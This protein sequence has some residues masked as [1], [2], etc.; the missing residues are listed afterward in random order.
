MQENNNKFS[1]D[2]S[3]LASSTVSIPIATLIDSSNTCIMN[4]GFQVPGSIGAAILYNKL[5]NEQYIKPFHNYV[6]GIVKK[7][8]EPNGPTLTSQ[9]MDA[10]RN[11]PYRELYPKM[12][13]GQWHRTMHGHSFDNIIEV[14]KNSKLK[15]S[16]F[17]AHELTDFVTKN[18][19]PILPWSGAIIKGAV[20]F[21]NTVG[22]NLSAS[23]VASKISFNFVEAGYTLMYVA[24]AAGDIYSVVTNSADWSLEYSKQVM[25]E[26]GLA[27]VGGFISGQKPIA[28][29]GAAQFASGFWEYYNTPTLL[30]VPVYDIVS[31][32]E[33]GALLSLAISGAA[34]YA[35]RE[36]LTTNEKLAMLVK[37]TSKAA[38]FSALSAICL[39]ASMLTSASYSVGKYAYNLALKDYDYINSSPI[40]SSLAANKSLDRLNGNIPP[41]LA[42]VLERKK[43]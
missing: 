28:A 21:A 35:N 1:T 6:E 14:Y 4:I 31:N 24:D 16:H 38:A 13:Q 22:I 36:H 15:V 30:S 29:V 27:V 41:T 7:I 39:P 40:T 10:T 9:W 37:N 18:G 12:V 42:R 17:L 5:P 2:F 19:L 33:I 25:F 8:V 34:I 26:G 11:G 23:A 32:A 43:Q 20:R 3:S